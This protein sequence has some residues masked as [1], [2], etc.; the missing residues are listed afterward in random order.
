MTTEERLDAL[1]KEIK[2]LREQLDGRPNAHDYSG[3]TASFEQLAGAPPRPR[4]YRRRVGF[5]LPEVTA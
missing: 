5:G 1:E 3:T 4:G 2:A